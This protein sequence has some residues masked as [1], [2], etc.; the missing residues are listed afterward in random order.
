M[1]LFKLTRQVFVEVLGWS[2]MLVLPCVQ[3]FSMLN[4]EQTDD[5]VHGYNGQ[6]PQLHFMKLYSFGTS[7]IGVIGTI[8]IDWADTRKPLNRIV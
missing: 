2:A 4:V 8:L 6:R 3:K 5:L 7:S 1:C